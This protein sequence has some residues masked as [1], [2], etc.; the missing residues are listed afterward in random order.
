MA[1]IVSK[2]EEFTVGSSVKGKSI[3]ED[4]DLLNRLLDW[5]SY[6]PYV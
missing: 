6:S 5:W 4:R 2:L 3:D 1:N